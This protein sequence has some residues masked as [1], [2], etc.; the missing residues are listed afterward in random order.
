M[1]VIHPNPPPRVLHGNPILHHGHNDEV[2][3]AQSRLG[4]VMGWGGELW[5]GE[6]VKTPPFGDP[7]TPLEDLAASW[8]T[9]TGGSHLSGPEEQH[10]V[11]C[12]GFPRCFLSCQ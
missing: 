8:R 7:V 4:G 11:F 12:Y 3:D 5:G 9:P 2:G 6:G 1:F 10:F